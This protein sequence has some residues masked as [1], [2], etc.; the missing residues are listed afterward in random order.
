MTVVFVTFG[1][2]G[3]R[4][5]ITLEKKLTVIGRKTDADLRIP[6]SEISRAH[7]EIAMNGKGV[8]LRDL[9]SSNGTFVNGER[10]EEDTELVAGDRVRIGP[11]TFIV[12]ID[13]K[14][15]N[16]TAAQLI[17]RPSAPAVPDRKAPAD[18]ATEVGKASDSGVDDLS[19]L[20][21]DELDELDVDELSDIDFTEEG[22]DLD[23][24]EE[25]GEDD[26]IDDDDD[27]D[28]RG[29]K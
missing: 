2:S 26:L 14:P 12:Q 13:G 23:A 17:S 21:I 24:L 16:V 10:V 18:A 9:G 19:D 29:T 15:A 7:C 4:K 28:A 8:T 27:T 22:G 6:L 25:L 1:K 3:E 5:E 20:D 11:V